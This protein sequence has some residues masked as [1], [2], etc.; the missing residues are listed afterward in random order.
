MAANFDHILTLADQALQAR[1]WEEALRHYTS[2]PNH[3]R[4]SELLQNQ[5]VCYFGLRKYDMA[6]YCSGLAV[7]LLSTMWRAALIYGKSIRELGNSEQWDKVI[8]KL[9]SQ[10]PNNPDV[11]IEYATV[12]FE[13]RCDAVA[14]QRVVQPLLNHPVWAEAAQRMRLQA[15]LYDRPK[16][17]NAR[18]YFQETVRFADEFLK[19]PHL[20]D[21]QDAALKAAVTVLERQGLHHKSKRK[22]VGF[23]SGQFFASPVYFFSIATLRRLAD[24]GH[25][26]VFFARRSRLD[27]AAREFRALAHHWVDCT[28]MS[29]SVLN[30][31]FK[32]CQ[33]DE[34]FDMAGQDDI[35]VLKAL[36]DKPAT[37]QFKW[38][39][40]QPCSTGMRCFDGF[41]TDD[42]LT[43]PNTY[44]LYSESLI[45]LGKHYVTYTPPPYMPVPQPRTKGNTLNKLLK[46]GSAIFGVAANPL[47]LSE[48][49]MVELKRLMQ[50][51][52]NRGGQGVVLRFIDKRFGDIRVADR[53]RQSLQVPEA[54]LEFSAPKDHPGF[55]DQLNQL[56]LLF[57]TFPY[58]GGATIC[59]AR[60]LNVPV[61]LFAYDRRLFC[62]RYSIS[63]L[64]R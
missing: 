3:Q 12:L 41:I 31:V 55:L 29:A 44:D 21:E 13:R 25:E 11:M 4:H 49:F 56:D 63:H 62:E 17:M 36:S 22:R 40:G 35:E 23:V 28:G 53:V 14:V 6:A 26:L 9:A 60:H 7:R 61:H 8:T 47:K 10:H 52:L 34:L 27:W 58:S 46:S 45:S 2:L 33:V 19:L 51:I 59:E 1:R 48:A 16:G 54:M 20:T 30:A 32:Y 42:R 15:L 50:T 37:L 43:P 39:G 57:D 18:A 64:E 5:A 38:V 24:D